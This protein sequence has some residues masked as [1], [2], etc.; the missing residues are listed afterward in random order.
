MRIQESLKSCEVT[1]SPL[2]HL[3][4][5]AE[6]EGVGE[7]VGRHLPRLGDA[8]LGVL[9]SKLRWTRPSKMLL[10][11]FA[12]VVSDAMFGSR[13]GGSVLMLTLSV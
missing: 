4:V 6:E 5:P 13:L 7:P 2:V 3:S 10:I 9:P 1:V 8:R 11:T 12:D